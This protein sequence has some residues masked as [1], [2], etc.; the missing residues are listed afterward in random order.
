MIPK[1]SVHPAL[2]ESQI[3]QTELQPVE[4]VLSWYTKLCTESKIGILAAKL[5]KETFF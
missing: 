2:D 1:S 4:V 3:N 5:A